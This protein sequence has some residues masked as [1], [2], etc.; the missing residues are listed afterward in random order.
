[1]RS[2]FAILLVSVS[3]IEADMRKT[4]RSEQ[5]FCF[6]FL[7]SKGNNMTTIPTTTALLAVL[8][9]GVVATDLHGDDGV[10]NG[11]LAVR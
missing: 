1:V 3:K 9:L 8:L 5:R 2:H 7:F 11:A 6:R 4:I 10:L